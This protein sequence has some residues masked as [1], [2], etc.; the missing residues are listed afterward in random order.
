MPELD[1]WEATREIRRREAGGSRRTPV[2]ALTANAMRVDREKCLEC[3]MDDFVSKPIQLPQLDE[4]LTR[5]LT[6]PGAETR[7]ASKRVEAP[8]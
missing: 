6:K 2:I 5:H 3:G 7:L 1:G 4:I 8:E